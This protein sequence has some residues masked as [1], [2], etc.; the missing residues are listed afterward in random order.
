MNLYTWEVM[1]EDKYRGYW[2]RQIDYL[3]FG[4]LVS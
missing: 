1:G 3:D 2:R 4:S